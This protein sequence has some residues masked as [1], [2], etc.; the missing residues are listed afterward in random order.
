M[1]RLQQVTYHY[2]ESTDPALCDL[3]LDV[4]EGEFLLVSGPSGSVVAVIWSPAMRS[5]QLSSRRPRT[6]MR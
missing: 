1:I 2:P 5:D 3:T 6:Q 4:V